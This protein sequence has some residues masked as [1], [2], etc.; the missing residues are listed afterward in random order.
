MMSGKA[1]GGIFKAVREFISAHRRFLFLTHIGPDGDGLLACLA[2]SRYLSF[3]EKRSTVA[4]EGPG[5]KFL[6]AYD[7]EGLVR[8]RED[9]LVRD[10]WAESFDAI[11]VVDTGKPSRLGKFHYDVSASGLPIA[12]IDH[13]IRED[14]DY[15]VPA[16]IDPEA[17]SVGQ[18]IAEYLKE[19]GYVFDDPLIVRTLFA[20]L[21]YDTGHFR[22]TNSSEKTFYWA[23]RLVELGAKPSDAFSIFW[24][25]GTAASMKL[26]G[27]LMSG[28]NIECNGRLGWFSMS[29]EELDKFGVNRDEIE[30]YI[31]FPRSIGSIEVIASFTELENS[32]IRVS[33]R[34][35]GRISVHEVAVRFGGGGH[36]FASGARCRDTLENTAKMVTQA[37]SEKIYA[38]MGQN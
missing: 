37:L 30:E 16:A 13:H 22:F 27:H 2:F 35:K 24:E 8:S 14:D 15:D 3:Q 7:P 36:A 32:L 11:I 23:A 29:L 17:A 33:L 38:E 28:L 9:L 31:S 21:S 26:L 19:E 4:I 6:G 1:A 10:D 34:S 25:S 20:T 5:P 12:V 18:M